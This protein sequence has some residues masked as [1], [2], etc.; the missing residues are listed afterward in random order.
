MVVER[1]IFRGSTKRNPRGRRPRVQPDATA[2]EA[3]GPPGARIPGDGA[4][5]MNQLAEGRVGPTIE[6]SRR[7][8]VVRARGGGIRHLVTSR[9]PDDLPQF[10]EAVIEMF[11]AQNR[12]RRP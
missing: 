7:Y 6:H 1:P 2:D 3:V 4:Q 11:A 9:K 5:Q 8:V 10:N 12:L